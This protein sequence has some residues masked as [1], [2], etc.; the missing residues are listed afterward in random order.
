MDNGVKALASALGASVKESEQSIDVNDIL[1]F[2]YTNE[3]MYQMLVSL[4]PLLERRD[5][6]GYA[7]AR[8]TRV[9][10]AEAMEYLKRRDELIE[11]YGEPEL[12]DNGTPTGRTQLQIGSNAYKRFMDDLALYSNI[13]HR[14]LLFKIPY[15]EAIGKMSG[16][17]ILACEW[18]LVDGGDA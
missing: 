2:E 1:P 5:I 8:N 3:Q 16:T 9:L 11:K 14:P 15:E 10:Q 18:M 13:K 6:V 17:E 12:S 7:A 4:E